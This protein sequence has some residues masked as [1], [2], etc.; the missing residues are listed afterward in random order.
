MYAPLR[1]A[2]VTYDAYR[3]GLEWR[4]PVLMIHGRHDWQVNYR[5]AEEYMESIRAPY[6]AFFLIDDAAHAPMVTQA[7]RFAEVLIEHARPLADRPLSRADC[8]RR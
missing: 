2:I 1:E 8:T 4:I 3:Y 7:A 5:L 6:K